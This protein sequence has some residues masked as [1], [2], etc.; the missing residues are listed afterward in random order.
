MLIPASEQPPRGADHV[1]L[2]QAAQPV[3]TAGLHDI[4][5]PAENIERRGDGISAA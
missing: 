2:K 3:L 4:K 5:D 1:F